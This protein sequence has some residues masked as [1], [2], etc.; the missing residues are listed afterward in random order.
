MLDSN[1]PLV[2]LAD[3][4]NWDAF[5]DSFAKYYS[6]E[7]I[8]AKPIRLMVGLLILKQLENL[9][10]ENIVL[11]FKRNPYYQYFC[12]MSEYQPELPCEGQIWSI[13]EKE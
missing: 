12:K 1:D 10:D 9:S 6:S 7:G 2:V 11:Q 5:N 4:I 3:T 8:P 13:L